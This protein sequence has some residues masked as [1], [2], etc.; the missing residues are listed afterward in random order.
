MP[1]DDN[2]T[3]RLLF[4]MVGKVHAQMQVFREEIRADTEKAAAE[5]RA[6]MVEL[7]ARSRDDIHRTTIAT[8]SRIVQI[9]NR[10]DD[11]TRER[12]SRKHEVDERDMQQAAQLGAIRRH[13]WIGTLTLVVL[14]LVI[15]VAT[16]AYFAGR[17]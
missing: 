16:A 9:E 10:M 14:V 7:L 11:D 17:Q 2:S 6:Y 3:E 12:V 15:I 5:V 13:Q 8:H 1:P 4:E